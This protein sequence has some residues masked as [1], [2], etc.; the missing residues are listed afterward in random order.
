MPLYYGLILQNVHI[1]TSYLYVGYRC[2]II[3]FIPHL[4]HPCTRREVGYKL[5][6]N[7]I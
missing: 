2:S 3:P 1:I 7:D 6:I 4:P 5:Q